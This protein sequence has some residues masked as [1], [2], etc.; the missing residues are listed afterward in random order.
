MSLPV[1]LPAVSFCCCK[2]QK[3][4]ISII[5]FI[6]K[7]VAQYK[8]GG[9]VSLSDMISDEPSPASYVLLPGDSDGRH[10][11]EKAQPLC[12]A[13]TGSE[14]VTTCT[15]RP[16]HLRSPKGG[17]RRWRRDPRRSGGWAICVEAAK[18]RRRG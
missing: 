10:A 18:Q 9:H 11:D 17:L 16:S 3:R 8:E 5:P 2:V 15:A 14:E 12:Q 13:S 6:F 7:A 1:A 4:T